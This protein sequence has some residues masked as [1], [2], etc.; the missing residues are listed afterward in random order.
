MN[1]N[2]LQIV[3][4]AKNLAS[5]V[6]KEVG[7]DITALGAQGAAASASLAKSFDTVGAGLKKT[8][9]AF[10][11]FSIAAGVGLGIASKAAIDFNQQM[12]YLHTQAGLSQQDV[13]GLKDKVLGLA[14]AVGQGPDKLAEAFYHIASAGN[15][16]WSTAQMLDMLKL[17][18]E[19]AAVGNAS[20]D[21]TTYSLTSTMASNI[22]GAQTAA[23]A[24]GNLNAI[25][26]AGDMRFQDL[27][28]AISTG[29]MA[30]A[31][32]FGVDIRS[33]GTALATLTDNGEHADE[34]ST[35]LRM[36]MALMAAPS[37]QAAKLLGDIGMKGPEV[38]AATDSMTQALQEAHLTTLTLADDL[39]K[40]NG[41]MV[42][43]QDLKTHLEQSGLSADA[44]NALL[45][46]SFGGGRTDAAMLTMLQNLDRMDAKYKIIG[47]NASKFGDSWSAQQDTAAQKM[48]DFQAQLDVLGVKLGNAFLPTLEQLAKSLGNVADWFSSLSPATQGLITNTLLFAAT[49]GPLAIGLGQVSTGVGAILKLFSGASGLV[50]MLGGAEAAAGGAAAG[51]G[52]LASVLGA[53]W[54]V[55][56]VAAPV[57]ALV[58]TKNARAGGCCQRSR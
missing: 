40:P 9:D 23:E 53:L 39:R 11:P 2:L 14:P 27:N 45:S 24:M 38:K 51:S 46:K 10:L 22:K 20:L 28:G 12:E 19:G 49:L 34:A 17:S 43:L 57:I 16:I 7:G 42:A 21:D 36:T 4:T 50:G 18:A 58:G 15:G 3:L 33:M 6:I 25:V 55:A 48:K 5:S 41:I 44:A 47:D 13:E 26:G 52:A 31:A 54:P 8:G 56:L 30:T 32:T 37:Q 35:R 29:I 1:D